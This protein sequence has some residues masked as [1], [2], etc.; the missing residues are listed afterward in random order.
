[1]ADVVVCDGESRNGLEGAGE[2][3]KEETGSVCDYQRLLWK[4]E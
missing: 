3:Q 2:K 4:T 1:L